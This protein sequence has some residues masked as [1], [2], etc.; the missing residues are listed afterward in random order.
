MSEIFKYI[1][2]GSSFGSVI[3]V[4][5]YIMNKKKRDGVG[6]ASDVS[7]LSDDYTTQLLQLTDKTNVDYLVIAGL[8]TELLD[9]DKSSNKINKLAKIMKYGVDNYNSK[10]QAF[11]NVIVKLLTDRTIV[12]NGLTVDITIENILTY[13]NAM[14]LPSNALGTADKVNLFAK[15]FKMYMI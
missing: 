7:I 15:T 13:L 6:G 5:I 4:G 9:N 8:S 11:A 1:G 14:L 2:Y 12:K 3:G 10:L